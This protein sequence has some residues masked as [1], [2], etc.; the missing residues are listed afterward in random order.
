MPSILPFLFN[1]AKAS[2]ELQ[3]AFATGELFI[4]ASALLGPLIYTLNKD[5][6][7]PSSH[8]LRG[9]TFRT[10]KFP[11]SGYFIASSF[12]ILLTSSAAFYV[13]RDPAV[14]VKTML[15][16]RGISRLSAYVYMASIAIYFFASAFRNM[17]DE[18]DAREGDEDFARKWEQQP[19]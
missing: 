2:E 16:E 19:L 13:I 17:L 12:L 8:K 10:I 14:D 5:Y 9:I 7:A 6:G 1:Q 4:Y 3:K 15:N 18:F 11:H